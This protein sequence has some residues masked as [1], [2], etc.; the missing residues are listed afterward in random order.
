MNNCANHSLIESFD[1][2]DDLPALDDYNDSDNSLGSSEGSVD[3]YD[4]LDEESSSYPHST[5]AS[6]LS[7]IF[8]ETEDD[9]IQL[10]LDNSEDG[11]P[12]CEIDL[13]HFVS[14]LDAYLDKK[15]RRDGE[16]NIDVTQHNAS[17]DDFMKLS[18]SFSPVFRRVSIES[19]GSIL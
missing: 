11:E 6:Y 17:D 13:P 16:G 7:T 15:H 12:S 9:L 10:S 18:N 5:C 8:E 1:G 4:S 3:S 2:L 19:Y 14:S